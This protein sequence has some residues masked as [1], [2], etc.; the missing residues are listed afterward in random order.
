MSAVFTIQGGADDGKAAVKACAEEAVRRITREWPAARAAI[1]GNR[2]DLALPPG[3]T[4]T[5]ASKLLFDTVTPLRAP[6]GYRF[7]WEPVNNG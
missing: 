3:V 1:R 6:R 7:V 5:E 2:V 4:A